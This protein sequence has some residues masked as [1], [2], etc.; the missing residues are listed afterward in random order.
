M[1]E[2]KNAS[3]S[4]TEFFD[5]IVAIPLLVLSLAAIPFLFVFGILF[6]LAQK[7]DTP[8]KKIFCS[9]LIIAAIL[10]A[11]AIPWVTISSLHGQYIDWSASKRTFETSSTMYDL[12]NKRSISVM[13][14]FIGTGIRKGI[15][16]PYSDV[17][18][19]MQFYSWIDYVP[20]SE[21]WQKM[22]KGY[23]FATAE[24]IKRDHISTRKYSGAFDLGEYSIACLLSL[25][26]F[27][28][29]AGTGKWA[30]WVFKKKSDPSV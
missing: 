4:V 21:V 22:E 14:E 23:L 3:Q 7:A 16:Q 27:V 5:A 26:P 28:T 25:L 24:D 30:S 11:I 20:G 10:P 1:E 13:N 6:E 29:I 15:Y 12:E 19:P 18:Y 8:L 17:K 2:E 9:L